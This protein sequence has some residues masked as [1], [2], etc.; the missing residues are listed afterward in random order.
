M[1]LRRL[2]VPNCPR[3]LTCNIARSTTLY[4]TLLC[5]K[6]VVVIRIGRTIKYL[7]PDKIGGK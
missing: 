3:V 4:I 1:A 6:R 5:F 7:P 2:A